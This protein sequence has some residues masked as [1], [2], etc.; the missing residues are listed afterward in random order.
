MARI[1]IFSATKGVMTRCCISFELGSAFQ[2]S[3]RSYLTTNQQTTT[4]L[5]SLKAIAMFIPIERETLTPSTHSY[6]PT[7]E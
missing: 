5:L 7:F 3:F 4:T 6:D 1:E 2:M